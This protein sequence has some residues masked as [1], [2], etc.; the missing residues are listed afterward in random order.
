MA[1]TKWKGEG[2][3]QEEKP[4]SRRSQEARKPSSEQTKKPANR[5][6]GEAKKF[7]KNE[8]IP[9]TH[10]QL[11]SVGALQEAASLPRIQIEIEAPRPMLLCRRMM[12]FFQSKPVAL[13][14]QSSFM[15]YVS[16]TFQKFCHSLLAASD[17]AAA[18]A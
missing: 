7:L 16:Q 12:S 9:K 14:P 4:R 2:R 5:K 10:T 8:Q 15:F 17:R 18:L 11:K 1:L 3:S 13:V 6:A